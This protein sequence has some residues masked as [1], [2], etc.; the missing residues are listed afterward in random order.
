MSER[1]GDSNNIYLQPP[2][3]TIA[4]D[5]PLSDKQV[6]ADSFDLGLRIGPLYD[7]LRHPETHTPMAAAIYGDW[8]AG[9]TSAMKW[10]EGYLQA[11]N[12]DG[13]AKDKITTHTTW[14]YPWKYQTQEDV[15]RGLI[16][17]VILACMD[18]KD[19]D[20]KA[21]I[22]T[23]KDLGA[24]LG[25]S[26]IDLISRVK[27]S[28]G[29]DGVGKVETDLQYLDKI[30]ENA[31]EFVHPESAYLNSFETA[32]GEWVE[33]TLG[34]N[35]RMVVFI[36]DLDRCMPEVALRVLEA[37]KLYLNVDRL[38]FVV[39]VDRGVVDGLVKKHYEKL[40]LAPEKS[41]S[42]LAKMFQIEITIAPSDPQID[43]FL[44]AMLDENT[45]WQEF[46]ENE[47]EI[48]RTVIRELAAG[49]P[50]EIKRLVNSALM[51]GAGARLAIQAIE[52]AQGTQVFL[53][54]NV[55]DRLESPRGTLVGRD[56]GTKFFMAWSEAARAL[57]APPTIPISEEFLDSV[58][59]F[60]QLRKDT[61]EELKAAW[62]D[63]LQS[64]YPS[65]VA[66]IREPSFVDLLS[67]LSDESL[68]ALMN[69]P[70]PEEA[71]QIG[72][73]VEASDSEGIIRTAI[74]RKLN[75]APE[76]QTVTH[77]MEITSLELTA[78]EVADL[79][80]L[81]GMK[82]LETLDLI[83]S[84]VSDIS[85]LRGLD[86]LRLLDLTGTQVRN[87]SPLRWLRNLETLD[88]TGTKVSILSP[89]RGLPLLRTLVLI[90]TRVSDVS[91][92]RQLEK[93][94][95]LDLSNTLVTDIS[96]LSDLKDLQSLH[97]IHTQVSDVSP[98]RGLKNLQQLNLTGTPLND[99]S[100]LRGL[101]RL[102]V[103][104][105]S[106]TQTESEDIRD[107]RESLPNCRVIPD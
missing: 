103:L 80:L 70:Y 56:L 27:L 22:E 58:R 85:P 44:D 71:A 11:W 45:A 28:V 21:L 99:I 14:F 10:L 67:L 91:S 76:V 96:P 107:L 36:D 30:R 78:A 47:Q 51:A 39:G 64:N 29:L 93:L 60:H 106:G 38:I 24:F 13:K 82:N 31:K 63:S 52:P 4:S 65:Y 8:G 74:A 20:T 79:S 89:L 15:W 62:S 32:F 90:N 81:S 77:L 3:L 23:A 40:G 26:F 19:L 92:L 100:P 43:G 50:R 25:E 69:I 37:L 61:G 57:K 101:K 5:N 55:L 75:V 84:H 7:I 95:T 18:E 2:W 86:K 48:F 53:V 12:T 88:L 17:Q 42:Y 68:G 102:R 97:L 87:I 73:V 35:E 41:G 9:K 104:N 59:D 98:L 72:G 54:R 49:S 34:K 105:L 6:E 94:Q 33:K 1:I 46:E 16:A 66:L 83:G